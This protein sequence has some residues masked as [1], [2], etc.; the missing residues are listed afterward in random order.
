MT[1]L[2]WIKLIVLIAVPALGALYAYQFTGQARE[3]IEPFKPFRVLL[4][5]VKASQE[6]L[7][8]APIPGAIELRSPVTL[9]NFWATWCPPCV[10][11]F[12]AMLEL[13]RRLG[14]KGLEV[15]FVSVDE[16]WA[17]VGAFFEKHGLQVDSSRLYWDP[18]RSLTESWGS[19][20]YPE[21]YVVRRDGWA[22]EKIIGLQQWTRPAVLEYF[23]NL[24]V[25]FA[26]LGLDAKGQ[27]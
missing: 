5:P 26:D 27:K 19:E 14:D 7:R 6:G 3:I 20:K 25:K 2:H 9:V 13:Q 8:E 1:K 23:E 24:T 18:D 15:V 4:G 17:D 21:S 16:N 11:E 10:E 22:V 12:P